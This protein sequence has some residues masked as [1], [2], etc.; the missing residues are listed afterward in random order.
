VEGHFGDIAFVL[1][2]ELTGIV[3]PGLLAEA[4]KGTAEDV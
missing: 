3:H 1:K 4:E 2:E